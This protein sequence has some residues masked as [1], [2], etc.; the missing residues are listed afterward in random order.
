MIKLLKINAYTIID[1]LEI[2]FEQGLNVITGETGA[3]KSVIID[4]IDIALGA[5]ASKELIKT[6]ET[7]AIIELEIELPDA[8]TQKISQDFSLEIENNLL[9]I[10]REITQNSSRIRVN[11]ILISQNALLEI[12]TFILDIH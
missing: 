9:I 10:T 6:G 3:G 1:E 8:L 7:R 2:E 5:K 12:R 4:A 11:G